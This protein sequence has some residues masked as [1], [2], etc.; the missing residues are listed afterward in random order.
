[1]APCRVLPSGAGADPVLVYGVITSLDGYVADESGGFDWARPD[2]EVHGFVN[3]RERRLGTHLYG[4]RLYEVM[5]FWETAGVDPGPPSPEREYAGIW[6][7]SDKVVYSSTLGGVDTARTRLERR[8]EPDRVR[9]LLDSAGH[10]VGIGGP[11]LA[12]HA[13]RAGLVD[14]VELVVV[15]V[16]VGAGTHWLPPGLRLDLELASERRF[17]HGAVHLGYRVRR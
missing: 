15:P 17:G 16:L 5:R 8:F 3:E 4:R 10:D 6:R 7:D 13:L 12:A 14:E 2:D 11:G 9:E 1:M